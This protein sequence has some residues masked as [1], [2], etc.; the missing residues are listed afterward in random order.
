MTTEL[1][2]QQIE[3]FASIARTVGQAF[4]L[5]HTLELILDVLARKLH[6]TRA[7]VTTKAPGEERFVVR[8]SHGSAPSSSAG[9]LFDIDDSL[10]NAISSERSPFVVIEGSSTPVL[11][12]DSVVTTLDKSYV[13]LVGAPV[14]LDD[15]RLGLIIVDRL[16]DDTVPVEQ[17]VRFLD[18]LAALIA[19]LEGLNRNIRCRED[20]LVRVN[21]ALRT[22]LDLRFRNYFGIGNSRSVE[23]VRQ[24]IR[25]VAPTQ[26]TPLLIGEAGTGRNNAARLIHDQSKRSRMPFMSAHMSALKG[27]E[28]EADIFGLPEMS[29]T[30]RREYLPGLLER[31][32]GG[33]VFLQEIGEA[34][35]TVQAKLL[36]FL[37]DG[38]FEPVDDAE[39]RTADTRIIVGTTRDLQA[40]VTSG[41]FR[42]DLFYR[43]NVI[44]I[45]LPTIRERPEDIE[46][47]LAYLAQSM[48]VEHGRDL[49]FSPRALNALVRH[50]WPANVLEME[51]LVQRLLITLDS[52]IVHLRDVLPYLS[53]SAISAGLEPRD[54]RAANSLEEMEKRRIIEALGNNDWIQSRA[55]REL[56]IT[57]RQMGYRVR[58]F[59]LEKYVKQKRSPVEV[60]G[61]T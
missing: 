59:G 36:R 46:P 1:S 7:R 43:L 58:K 20:G 2:K 52:D 16:F 42:E 5:E 28:S 4:N 35:P 14:I 10:L 3:A 12:S 60:P 17:D 15:T 53:E 47:L 37:N 41:T 45:R 21:K 38:E 13:S 33:T 22:E 31:A 50:P 26:A 40:D 11:L 49:S 19:E 25:Q 39:I 29:R 23:E 6:M 44:P 57:L 24:L 34:T 48:G 27:P 9:G 8:A 61:M 18:A 51:N 54:A 30:G 55:A 56:G 32:E